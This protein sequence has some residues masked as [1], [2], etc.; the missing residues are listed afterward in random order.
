MIEEIAYNGWKN[1]LRLRGPKTELVITLDVG[2]RIIRYA[3]HDGPNVFVELKEQIGGANEKEWMIRGGHRFWTAPEADHS[4]DLDNKSVT[5]K[6]LGDDTV[7]LTQAPSKE[8]GFQK[9][10]WCA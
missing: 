2:P 8:F 6:K 7:E 9:R 10:K 4:Y 3:L 5:W 1:N